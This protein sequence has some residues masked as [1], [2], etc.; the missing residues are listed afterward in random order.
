MAMVHNAANQIVA[1]RGMLLNSTQNLPRI[2][3]LHTKLLGSLAH[4]FQSKV[5]SYSETP[6]VCGL[7]EWNL[8]LSLR[9]WQEEVKNIKEYFK[10][11]LS[12]QTVYFAA[13]KILNFEQYRQ[14]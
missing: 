10:L 7:L 4:K 11:L 12:S 14:I 1:S 3:Q 8:F 13:S 6:D 9:F 5:Q 2:A